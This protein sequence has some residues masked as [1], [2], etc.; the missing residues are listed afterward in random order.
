[1]PPETLSDFDRHAWCRALF[2]S[3]HLI[4]HPTTSRNPSSTNS[5]ESYSLF[6]STLW[7][8]RG[9]RAVQSFEKPGANEW[10]VLYSLGMGLNGPGEIVHGGIVMTILDSAMAVKAFQTVGERPVVTTEFKGK[11]FR[12]VK[13]PNVVLC[14]AWVEAEEGDGRVIYTGGRVEDGEGN[15]FLEATAR[16]VRLEEIKSNLWK[17]KCAWCGDFSSYCLGASQN[18]RINERNNLKYRYIDDWPADGNK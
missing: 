14:R 8:E 9:L 5:S 1:M 17:I 18:E 15:A 4:P 10:L 2:A 11:L 6:S 12:K 3:P 7:N 16:F 13:A